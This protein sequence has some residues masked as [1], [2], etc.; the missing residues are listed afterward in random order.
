VK[1]KSRRRRGGSGAP[2]SRSPTQ[3]DS[4][5]E[6]VS[7]TPGA[8]PRRLGS[9]YAPQVGRMALRKIRP[10]RFPEAG[11]SGTL[12]A[13][14]FGSERNAAPEKEG[15]RRREETGGVHQL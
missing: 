8:L 11:S 9:L 6:P 7:G 13:G 12:R 3:K 14:E 5:P 15:A 1:S 4:F 2:E 10:D